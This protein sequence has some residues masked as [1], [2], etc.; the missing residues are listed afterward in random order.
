MKKNNGDG[1]YNDFI[2]YL[3]EQNVPKLSHLSEFCRE[4]PGPK[5]NDII[6][7]MNF[8]LQ[9]PGDKLMDKI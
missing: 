8:D 7:R 5:A 1:R 2:K 4:H 3:Q 6:K 9:T